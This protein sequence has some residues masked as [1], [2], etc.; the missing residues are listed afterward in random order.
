MDYEGHGL[1]TDPS[2][3]DLP[4]AFPDAKAPI[5]DDVAINNV[6]RVFQFIQALRGVEKV[7]FRDGRWGPHERDPSIPFGTRA[8]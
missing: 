5:H 8:P 2:I 1:S 3:M 6:E 7:P 4:A